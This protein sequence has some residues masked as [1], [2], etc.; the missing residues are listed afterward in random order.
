MFWEPAAEKWAGTKW[1]A[2]AR[3]DPSA[4]WFFKRCRRNKHLLWSGLRALAEQQPV[5]DKRGHGHPNVIAA[6]PKIF[7]SSLLKLFS[8]FISSFAAGC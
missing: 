6:A 1:T 7:S 2:L 5:F 8:G 4:G 3:F